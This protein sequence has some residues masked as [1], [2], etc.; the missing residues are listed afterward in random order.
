MS[1]QNINTVNHHKLLPQKEEQ[2][3]F[4]FREDPPL[5]L[6][7]GRTLDDGVDEGHLE[8][9]ASRISP[10]PQV[11]TPADSWKRET[12]MKRMP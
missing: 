8:E 7:S 11:D 2:R 10:E 4:L 1:W 12:S 5:P 6:Q 3:T 9:E